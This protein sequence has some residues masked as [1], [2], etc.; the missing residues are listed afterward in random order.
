M[1]AGKYRFGITPIPAQPFGHTQN[2]LQIFARTPVFP[3]LVDLL[4]GCPDHIFDLD[5]LFPVGFI[6]RRIRLKIE[7]DGTSVGRFKLRQFDD[8]FACNHAD[9]PR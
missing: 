2:A 4:E 1:G 3:A 7:T 6:L 9:P 8:V 5:R